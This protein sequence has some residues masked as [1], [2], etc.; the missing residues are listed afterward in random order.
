MK[1]AG[2]SYSAAQ[3]RAQDLDRFH[4]ALCAPATVQEA[5]LALAAFNLELARTASRV[6]D[7]NLGRIRLQWWREVLEELAGRGPVRAHQVA[8]ALAECR[9]RLNLK[10]LHEMVDA[11]ERD[12]R[13]DEQPWADAADLSAYLAQTQGA[14]LTA[15]AQAL[16]LGGSEDPGETEDLARHL[17]CA[18]GFVVQA[19]ALAGGKASAQ[20]M[21]QAWLDDPEQGLASATD[22]AAKHLA[23]AQALRQQRRDD[24][25]ALETL[26]KIGVLTARWLRVF[27]NTKDPLG[28]AK[29]LRPL[30][31]QALRLS[32]GF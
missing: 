8:L 15:Q 21:P 22:A 14:L 31:F 13:L 4:L 30:P 25:K 5:W 12:L 11:R 3:V 9:P 23:Q 32:F 26:F 20:H 6:T 16:G 18:H 24:A 7:A 2:L 17:G 19:R 27:E 10:V 29:F 1:A 28:K